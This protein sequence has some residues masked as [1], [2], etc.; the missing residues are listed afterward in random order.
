MEA[1]LEVMLLAVLGDYGKTVLGT[2]GGQSQ[3][4]WEN[5]LRDYG[6]T[7]SGDYGR[8]CHHETAST[9]PIM[10]DCIPPNMSQNK[11]L[12]VQLLHISKPASVQAAGCVSMGVTGINA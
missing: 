1:L 5:S 2:I 3:G 6:R 9:F 11:L 7:V 12:P 4:L 8:T 10:M